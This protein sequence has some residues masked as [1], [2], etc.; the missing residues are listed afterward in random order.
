[1]R[2]CS[3]LIGAA[4]RN[5]NIMVALI[6]AASAWQYRNVCGKCGSI[7][8]ARQQHEKHQRISCK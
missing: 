8:M 7:S 1:M 3:G 4:R 2:R 5:I 6:A